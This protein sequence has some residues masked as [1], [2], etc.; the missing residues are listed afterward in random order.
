MHAF[1]RL[2][3]G[4]LAS[5]ALVCAP[6][7]A[8]PVQN[9]AVTA[10][11][12]QPIYELGDTIELTITG[13]PGAWVCILVDTGLGSF[14]LP[15]LIT[16]DLA[17]TPSFAVTDLG[18]L[19]PS[20][21]LVLPLPTDCTDVGLTQGPIYVQVAMFPAA[22]PLPA[23][24]SNVATL[25]VGNGDCDACPA[26]ATQDATVSSLPGGM[27]LFLPG[28][29]GDFVFDGQ[30]EI[31]ERKDGTATLRG[32]IVSAANPADRF[33]LQAELTGRMDQTD[34]AFP[35]AGSP[36]KKLLPGAFTENGGPVDTTNW[37]YYTDFSGNLVGLDNLTGALVN[38]ND[39][40]PAAQLGR[41]ANGKNLDFGLC[42]GL[43]T[44]IVAQPAGSTQ[45][46]GSQAAELTLQI[47]T[48]PSPANDVCTG[49][50]QPTGHVLWWPEVST[51]FMPLS[52]KI[53]FEEY[54]DGTAHLF[55]TIAVQGE[56]EKC[57][58][59]DVHFSGRLDFGDTAFPP[60][61]SPKWGSVDPAAADENTWHY[62]EKSEGALR[63][64]GAYDGAVIAL[65]RKG[66]AFQVGVGANYHD[67]D[68]GGSGWFYMTVLQQ[69]TTGTQFTTSTSGDIN[70]DFT[71]CPDP[72]IET[73]VHYDFSEQVGLDVFDQAGD[74]D[75]VFD[76][77]DGQIDWVTYGDLRGVRLTQGSSAN[78]SVRR[79]AASSNVSLANNLDA[80][81][82]LTVQ[83]LFRQ[84]AT[85]VNDSRLVTFS[86]SA[87]VSDRNFSLMAYPTSGGIEG[88]VRL[89]TTQGTL[90]QE[91]ATTWHAGK[92]AVMAMTY[93]K[94]GVVRVYHDGKLTTSFTHGGDFSTWQDRGFYLGN[95]AG[96]NRPFYG[97]LYD[98]KIWNRALDAGELTTE[99]AGLLAQGPP[100]PPAT[101]ALA[102]WDFSEQTGT[103]VIDAVGGI[104]LAF[105][106]NDFAWTNDST[107]LG[108]AFTDDDG[109]MLK[110]DS[111]STAKPLR[112][113]L[114]AT[115]AVTLQVQYS[116][117]DDCDDDARIFTWSSSTS[118]SDRNLSMLSDPKGSSFEG[119]LR[120]T[121]T[122]GTATFQQSLGMA[123]DQVVV[124]TLT[125]DA[126]EGILRA[127]LDGALLSSTPHS[128]DFSNWSDH[129]LRF[130]NESGGKRSFEG[131]IYDIKIWDRALDAGEV[132]T[133]AGTL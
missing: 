12:G 43:E 5:L 121:T 47:G 102:H 57:F 26:A 23:V 29:G 10:T 109:D 4:A 61:G 40:G 60:S 64:C 44:T 56:S 20:G 94:D 24:T 74:F 131:V 112:E 8:A 97:E 123:E 132:A 45:L 72:K 22:N 55:G 78:T 80:E 30:A 31:A 93:G 84:D 3:A 75:L 49:P 27:A 54:A 70:L 41:G 77:S 117:D 25:L 38:V 108:L 11:F 33:I 88:Q 96:G 90:D 66:P 95:E 36:N 111:T 124:Y 105:H 82:A 129:K 115:N 98:V 104:D 63:G 120:L 14:T 92:L 46:A 37:H 106:G 79:A 119:E 62:Y 39:F 130:G 76:V 85:Q 133:E 34:A 59:L 68:D 107:G 87:S 122:S 118:V 83:V 91:F 9:P 32:V 110:T 103:H 1:P 81:D 48:C 6:A 67:L 21:Q 113:A 86:D 28:L 65:E 15:G 2:V 53:T 127:Y 100:A 125:Y 58:D 18:P 42:A 71:S 73:L 16:F 19:P 89:D 114:Q 99:A 101:A 69:P 116:Q 50:S 13:E 51:H 17:Y 128:G 126:T 7:A 35:P 52:D